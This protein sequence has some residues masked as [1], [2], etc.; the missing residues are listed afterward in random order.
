MPHFLQ[1]VLILALAVPATALSA[2][3]DGGQ[4]AGGEAAAKA[5]SERL[6]GYSTFQARFTQFLADGSGDR[7]QESRGELKARR[8]GYFYWH[9]EPPLEQVIVSDSEEVIVYDP[10]L[11]QATVYPMDQKLSATPALLLS[12][13]VGDL[14]ESFSIRYEEV[15]SSRH[16]F[17]LEPKEPDSLFLEL[18]LLFED[19]VLD[20]MRLYDAMEQ[21]SVLM[22]DDVVL[23]ESIDDDVFTLELDDSVDVIRGQAGR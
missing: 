15:T 22:F 4:K 14:T 12:G 21:L 5:L 20:E 18:K 2:D 16:R 23:N 19:G 7:V 17:I 8:P 10:D 6:S 13:E 11:L 1:A 9:S 3:H